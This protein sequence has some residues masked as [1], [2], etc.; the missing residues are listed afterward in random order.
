MALSTGR[1]AV[2]SLLALSFAHS[3]EALR[4]SEFLAICAEAQRPCEDIPALRAYVG[5]GLDLVATLHEETDYV[6]P[7]YCKDPEILFDVP[8]IVRYIEQHRAGNEDSNAMLLVV[9][10]L[11]TYG[12]C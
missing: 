10:F 5:G 1:F 12:G 3:A 4:V 2:F 6:E 11:E 8:A 9:R 7:I